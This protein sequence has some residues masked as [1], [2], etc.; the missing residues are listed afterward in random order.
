MKLINRSAIMVLPLQPYADW[1]NQL[2]PAISGLDHPM[3]LESHRREGR[4]YLVDEQ[5]D[6]LALET[7]VPECWR[8]IFENELAAWDEFADS[9]PGGLSEILFREWFEIQ[10]LLLAFDLGEDVLMT[11][12]LDN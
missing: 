4:V 6:A 9:W 1:V 8:Q 2:N 11:A 10:P 3:E 12:N 7:V 5:E